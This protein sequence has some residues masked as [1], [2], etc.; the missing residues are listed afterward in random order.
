MGEN[1]RKSIRRIR[2]IIPF[3]SP[4]EKVKKSLIP[5]NL[6]GIIAIMCS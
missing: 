2:I 4:L 5:D 3:R 1:I 6:D